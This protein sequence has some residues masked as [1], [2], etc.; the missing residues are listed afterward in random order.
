L[1][2]DVSKVKHASKTEAVS[3]SSPLARLPLPVIGVVFIPVALTSL[4]FLFS[5]IRQGIVEITAGFPMFPLLLYITI[6][7]LVIAGGWLLLRRFKITWRDIGFANFRWQDL[8][9]AA[10]AALV[11]L[12]L[13][14]PAS[15][16]IAKAMGLEAIK[17]MSYSLAGPLNII[18]A[19]LI[20][21]LLGPLAEDIL[22]RG[23]LLNVLQEKLRLKWVVGLIG[24]LMFTIIHIPGFGWSGTLFILLWSPLSVGLFLWRRSIYPSL[25]LHMIN[26][27]VAYVLIPAVFHH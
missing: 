8:G 4:L 2:T 6:T 26:N 15:T 18:S 5:S 25:V 20:A 14:Y 1:N 12:F 16:L 19:V 23:F 7:W 11:G 22:F 27:L 24:V 3:M 9:L 17:G 13:I 10:V 21:S